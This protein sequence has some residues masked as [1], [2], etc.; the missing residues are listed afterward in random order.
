MTALLGPLAYSYRLVRDAAGARLTVEAAFDPGRYD[1]DAGAAA[2]TADREAFV[3]VADVLTAERPLTACSLDTAMPAR[4]EEVERAREHTAAAVRWLGRRLGEHGGTPGPAPEPVTFSR[5]LAT[6]SPP[7]VT[8]VSVSLVVG[9]AT[10][11]VAP[12]GD[13]VAMLA[14]AFGG[15]LLAAYGPPRT[16]WPHRTVWALALAPYALSEARVYA[17]APLSTVPVDLEVSV[18]SWDEAGGGLVPAGTMVF[19][20][21]DLARFADDALAA[22]ERADSPD[23]ARTRTRLAAAIASGLRPMGT[24]PDGAALDEARAALT[25]RL[26]HRLTDRP[27]VV[28][29]HEL[30]EPPAFPVVVEGPRTHRLA[31]GAR[32]LTYAGPLAGPPGTPL[33]SR[34][35]WVE[36]QAGPL[37]VVDPPVATAEVPARLPLLALPL[38]PVAA[39]AE[40]ALKDPGDDAAEALRRAIQWLVRLEYAA[41]LTDDDRLDVTLGLAA[42]EPDAR[43]EADPDAGLLAAAPPDL[44]GDLPE[45]LARI[46]VAAPRIPP[47]APGAAAALASLAEGLDE[48]WAAWV[49]REPPPVP[50]DAPVTIREDTLDGALRVTVA[51]SLPDGATPRVLVEGC[52]AVDAPP[53][54]SGDNRA[55]R[56]WTYRAA[57]GTPLSREEGAQRRTLEVGWLD[58]LRR[59]AASPTLRVVRNADAPA[60]F[61]YATAVLGYPRVAPSV[62]VDLRLD[63][64]ALGPGPRPLREHLAAL[65]AALTREGVHPKAQ[66]QVSAAVGLSS[67]P[68]TVLFADP[69]DAEAAD[70]LAAHVTAWR[71]AGP[72]A[73]AVLLDVTL[74]GGAAPVRLS[75]LRLRLADVTA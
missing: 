65:F 36:H 60:A 33:A 19:H 27:P 49:G 64:A 22:L 12:S 48:A 13:V 51:Y 4:D 50:P 70:R 41:E 17:L 62:S 6:P 14:E 1:G 39:A 16:G 69:L 73:D 54:P 34:V 18:H 42:P 44:G 67:I 37:E 63:V 59:P 2:A 40:P 55:T 68:V 74:A 71:E 20:G 61:A 52:T 3:A 30:A 47:G 9:D 53:R 7:E 10:Q 32:T 31:A 57:D 24:E 23:L 8:E 43:P 46:V 38:P 28:L 75:G 26:L 15:A 72:P 35:G 5:T 21:I 11:E 45:R 25:E 58:A 66:V 56:A 29:Q